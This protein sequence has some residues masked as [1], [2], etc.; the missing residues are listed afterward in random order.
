M[1]H[2]VFDIILEIFPNTPPSVVSIPSSVRS[3][4]IPIDEFGTDHQLLTVLEIDEITRSL[5]KTDFTGALIDEH[6]NLEYTPHGTYFRNWLKLR[7]R[8]EE[9]TAQ[10]I[11]ARPFAV[12]YSTLGSA[13]AT[14]ANE[15]TGFVRLDN[16][17]IGDPEKMKEFFNNQGNDGTC[18]LAAVGSI[19]QSSGAGTFE[20]LLQ[21]STVGVDAK[22]RYVVLDANQ[23]P[24]FDEDGNFVYLDN[25]GG[26]DLLTDLFV[27][28]NPMYVKFLEPPTELYASTLPNFVYQTFAV[29]RIYPNPTLS[30]NWGWIEMIFDEYNIP[31]HTG[32]ATNFATIV[33]EIGAGNQIVAFVDAT[34]LWRSDSFL[35]TILES[36]WSPLTYTRTA[37]NHALWITG[38]EVEDGDAYVILNDSAMSDGAGVRYPL[39]DFVESFED[40]E[41]T[42]TATGNHP[43]P[44]IQTERDEI[45]QT[46]SDYYAGDPNSR[47][48][49]EAT[50]Q[51]S[52]PKYLSDTELVYS[53]DQENPGFKDK[54]EAYK[55]SVETNR[56]KVLES[57]GV[58]PDEIAKIYE[59]ADVE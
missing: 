22:G 38:I 5:V 19:L 43:N 55:E 30:Q 56:R 45:F 26:I 54:A 36:G 29:D 47:V 1:P 23:N 49:D 39:K 50:L 28:G 41:F 11:Q 10:T 51:Q 24:L 6:N 34:E 7:M 46:V 48:R 8:V 12:P 52:L 9:R 53:I 59:E 37:E 15:I 58:D 17:V 31:N 13:S 4:R 57:I 33:E 25:H 32:Y 44:A 14:Y 18:L 21:R 20:E 27:D 42:Y 16:D 40:S 35:A 3:F 2:D